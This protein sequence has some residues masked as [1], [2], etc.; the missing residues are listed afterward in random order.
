[1]RNIGK[2]LVIGATGFFLMPIIPVNVPVALINM[3]LRPAPALAYAGWARRQG[4]GGFVTRRA[5][6]R[7]VKP[8]LSSVV[9]VMV[10]PAV[11]SL[12]RLIEDKVEPFDLVFI[13]AG[14]ESNPDYLKLSVKLS[15]PGTV[16]VGDN[17]VR[18][19]R[20]ADEKNNDPDVLGVRS[21]LELL[22]ADSRLTTTAVQTVGSKGWDGFSISV[23]S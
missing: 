13:D 15:R 12:E 22:A 10:G 20:V 18:D 16:I 7:S 6:R 23:V 17:V 4:N 11:R 8:G 2:Y 14:K 21:F 3:M 1:M 9:T 5:L 19:G